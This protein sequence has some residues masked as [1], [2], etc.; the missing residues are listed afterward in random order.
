M[1][2]IY[3]EYLDRLAQNHYS[4]ISNYLGKKKIENFDRQVAKDF[5]S[6]YDFQKLLLAK[7][8][9][10]R[11]I[12]K[13]FKGDIKDYKIFKTYYGYLN[14]YTNIKFYLLG[15]EDSNTET[16]RVDYNAYKLVKDLNISTCPYCNRGTIYNLQKSKGRTSEIDHFYSKGIYPYFAISFYNLI[17]SCKVCNKLKMEDE[18]T[19]HPYEKGFEETNFK[20]IIKD[21]RFYHSID[22]FD[23]EFKSEDTKINRQI[24]TFKLDDLYQ[25]HKDIILELIQKEAIY[26]ESYLDELLIQYEGTVFKNREDL[27]RIISGGYITDEEI[28]KRPLSKLIKDI[29]QELGLI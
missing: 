6:E 21:S 24:D 23:L 18:I 11:E 15:T 12:K 28:G 26:N 22:G 13:L 4:A 1:I 27:Q 17:P 7:P 14:S 19:M 20:L 16:K 29:S 8:H 10:L 3:H 5:S 9:E 25:N 2:K